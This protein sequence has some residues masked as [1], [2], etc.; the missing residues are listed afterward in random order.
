MTNIVMRAATMATFA[1][2][3]AW[4]G[5]ASAVLPPPTPAQAQAQAAKKAAADAQSKKDKLL[6]LARMDALSNAWR[7]K[8][9]ANGWKLNPPT[10]L[11]APGV[12]TDAGGAAAAGMAAISAPAT[13][14]GPSGQPAG[15]LTTT[16]ANAPIRSEKS[17]TAAPSADVKPAPSPAAT[18]VKT[19]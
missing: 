8:A 4:A 12:G 19:R 10:A 6:L 14:S 2:L 9:G 5:A 18:T 3:A 1:T 13:Q 7:D 16:G 11:A 17:G 15:V